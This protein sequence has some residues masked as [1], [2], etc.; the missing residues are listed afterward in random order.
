MLT[1][2]EG[3]R[4]V[5]SSTSLVIESASNK[6]NEE[7]KGDFE[8]GESCYTKMIKGEQEEEVWLNARITHVNDNN[9]FDIFVIDAKAHGVP[10]EAVNVPRVMLKKSSETVQTAVP[11]RKKTGGRPQIQPGTRI[12]V[13]G[14]RSHTTYNGMSGSA[15]LYMPA[16]RRYQVRLDS[17]D[18]I[19][20]KQRNVELEKVQEVSS[21]DLE[22]AK[23][24]TLKKLREAGNVTPAEEA[25]LSDLLLKLIGDS[26]KVD[27]VKLGEFA[28]GF[29]L[30]KET[31]W[32][33]VS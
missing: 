12:R 4:Q 25:A 23:Q 2:I 20:I 26:S 14:L 10:P 3:L 27:P 31:S 24:V 22:A 17:G 6:D 30:A 28:A 18:V 13:F 33:A 11:E 16:E 7:K 19:A 9:T 29:L 32:R 8:V 21:E 1:A 15:L 5:K